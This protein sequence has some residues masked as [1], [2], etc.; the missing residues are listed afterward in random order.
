MYPHDQG[1]TFNPVC[2]VQSRNNDKYISVLKLCDCFWVRMAVVIYYCGWVRTG[3]SY[4]R[5]CVNGSLCSKYF[6]YHDSLFSCQNHISFLIISFTVY[7]IF[8]HVCTMHIILSHFHLKPGIS[9][10]INSPLLWQETCTAS[11]LRSVTVEQRR[12][13]HLTRHLFTVHKDLCCNLSTS[14]DG[15]NDLTVN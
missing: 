14:Q 4:S 11:E 9:S 12:T 3:S 1:Y 8:N 15:S 10:Q 2:G 6:T 5:G 7:Y 13:I